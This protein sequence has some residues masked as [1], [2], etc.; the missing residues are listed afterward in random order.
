MGDFQIVAPVAGLSSVPIGDLDDLIHSAVPR[1][2]PFEG[3][4]ASNEPDSSARF[5]TYLYPELAGWL[6][7]LERLSFPVSEAAYIAALTRRNGTDFQ[8]ELLASGLVGEDSFCR[9]FAAEL[10]VGYTA[11]LNP[12]RLIV[13]DESAIESLRRR[14]W[15]IPVKIEEK[16]GSSSY[17]VSPERL[18]PGQLR[19]LLDRYPEVSKR[20]KIV[21]QGTLRRALSERVRIDLVKAVVSDLF[22]RY[23]ALSARIVANAWQGSVLGAG[24]MALLV[25]LL[26]APATTYAALHLCFSVFFLSCVGLRFAAIPW[27]PRRGDAPDL[28]ALADGVPVYSVLVALYKEQEIVPDLIAALGR[29]VWPKARLEIKLVCEEDDLA[30]LNAIGACDLPGHIEVVKVPVFGP[31]TKPKALAYALPLASG[32]FVA[33]FDAEDNPHPLQLVEAWRRFQE[34]GPDLACVQAPLEITNR[35]AGPVSLMFAFEYAALFRGLLPWLTRNRLLTPLGGTSNHFRRS[36]LDHVGGWDPYNVTEDADLGMRLARFAYRTEMIS[37]PT[38]EAGPERWSEWLP[39]RTR[40]L[41]GWVQ[42]WLVHMRDPMALAWQLG[43]G[44]FLMAQ[45]LFA[46]MVVSALIHPFL[47]V[48]A[49]V[50]A[51]ELAAERTMSTW[52]SNMLIFDVTNIACGYISFLLLGWQTLTKTERKTFWKIALYTPVYWMMISIAAWR[53]VWQLWQRPHHWEKTR[54]RKPLAAPNP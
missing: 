9:A 4:V 43:F 1:E 30:T 17:L 5:A 28:P 44:S 18:A 20:V 11:S 22:D 2:R 52:Q 13:P 25:S 46:G 26:A 19:A 16:S 10:D 45:I 41:K 27:S 42:T 14:N 8:S 51:L 54:H 47:I 53:A 12:G 6:P 37:L 35:R 15:R 39:Q 33:L 29:L 48:T 36:A 50:L 24:L 23:P 21:A 31:R 34:S 3:G 7:L 40:W 38:F 49:F 32:E